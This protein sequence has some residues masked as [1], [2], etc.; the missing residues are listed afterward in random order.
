MLYAVCGVQYSW[1]L[2]A[3]PEAFVVLSVPYLR[4]SASMAL[5]QMPQQPLPPSFSSTTEIAENG[6]APSPSSKSVSYQDPPSQ[7]GSSAVS[8]RY[9]QGLGEG[10]L[11]VATSGVM[12]EMLATGGA[13]MTQ[14]GATTR[15]SFRQDDTMRLSET[16]SIDSPRAV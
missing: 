5:P 9:S 11:W 3:R 6:G 7:Y 14:G 4:K 10:G 1:M 13:C 12:A 16:L 15:P 2:F 8:R